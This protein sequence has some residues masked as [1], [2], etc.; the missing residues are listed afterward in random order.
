M[1]AAAPTPN[2]PDDVLQA[3]LARVEHDLGELQDVLA[4]L[5][6]RAGPSALTDEDRAA[7]FANAREWVEQHFAVTFVR[8]LGGE[9]RWCARWDQHPEACSRLEAL[10]RTWEH[11]RTDPVTGIATWYRE[12]LDHHLPILLGNRGPFA[13]CT[14]TRH[15]PPRPLPVAP[16]TGL[17]PASSARD[18]STAADAN[19]TYRRP[20]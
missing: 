13:S 5:I 15:E 12:H 8:P 10:W 16:A 6:D 3:R 20:T 2:G 18:P 1:T 11:H 4:D 14:P 17:Q 7:Y 9:W 19:P